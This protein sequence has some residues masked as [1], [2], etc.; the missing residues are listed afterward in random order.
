[1]DIGF[2]FKKRP[3]AYPKEFVVARPSTLNFSA[4]WTLL[5]AFAGTASSDSGVERIFL[6]YEGQ[7]IVRRI[8]RILEKLKRHEY[9][10]T[11]TISP[12]I[13]LWTIS[14]KYLKRVK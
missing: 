9:V 14:R 2:Y 6:G 7:E 11:R 12:H 5:S 13:R 3:K 8:E 1:M 10:F 4:T